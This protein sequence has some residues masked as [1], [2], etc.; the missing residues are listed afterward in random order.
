MSEWG[1]PSGRKGGKGLL[2]WCP[3]SGSWGLFEC[4][5][6]VPSGLAREC[7]VVSSRRL[8]VLPCELKLSVRESFGPSVCADALIPDFSPSDAEESLWVHSTFF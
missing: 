1:S 2:G 7:V 3:P 6:F 8:T 4:R 5:W